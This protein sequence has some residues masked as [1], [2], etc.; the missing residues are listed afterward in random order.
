MKITTLLLA[1][2][3]ILVLTGGLVW[4]SEYEGKEGTEH[5]Y[6]YDEKQEAMIYGTIESIPIGIYGHWVVNGKNVLITEDTRM[7][8]EHGKVAVGAYVEIE[9]KYVGKVLEARK[10]EVKREKR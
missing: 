6:R 1:V 5:E 10:F 9:G 2:G 8:G 4:G 3:L 7:E